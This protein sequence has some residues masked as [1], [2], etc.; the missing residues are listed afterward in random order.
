MHFLLFRKIKRVKMNKRKTSPILT[1]IYFVLSIG[2][3]ISSGIYIRNAT[4][5]SA[6][7]DIL[8]AV[9]FGLIGILWVFMFGDGR[10][11]CQ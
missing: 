7:R 8:P 11:N 2:S 5:T 4:I 10:K 9:I 3:L 1:W 6:L